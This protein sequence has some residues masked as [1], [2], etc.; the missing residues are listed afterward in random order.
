MMQ[1]SEQEHYIHLCSLV[2]DVEVQIQELSLT[3]Q[4]LLNQIR[5]LKQQ[6]AQHE[7]Q[8]HQIPE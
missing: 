2:G 4:L 1:V 6:S 7:A 5:Q 3:K 8:V